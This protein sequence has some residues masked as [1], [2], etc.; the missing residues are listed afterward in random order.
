MPLAKSFMKKTSH[1]HMSQPVMFVIAGPNGA[2]KTTFYKTYIAH[3]TAAPFINADDIQRNELT[4]KS[5]E[6]AYE[7][8]SINITSMML[9]MKTNKDDNV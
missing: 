2:G 3:L 9:I 4:D 8:A 5:V 6:A 1:S 7:A